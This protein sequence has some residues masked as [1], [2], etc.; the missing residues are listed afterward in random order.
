MEPANLPLQVLLEIRDDI[1]EMRQDVG[2]IRQEIGHINTRLG[3]VENVVLDL[4]TQ[5]RF[6]ARSMGVSRVARRRHEHRLDDLERRVTDPER[7]R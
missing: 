5:A 2:G 1:A 6:M 4:A 3:S 7:K